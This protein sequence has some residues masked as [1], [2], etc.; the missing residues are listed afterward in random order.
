[1]PARAYDAKLATPVV[2]LGIRTIGQLLTEI[3][4]LPPTQ[5][6]SRQPMT[7]AARF[8]ASSSAIWRS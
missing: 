8:A 5:R 2:V 3:A 6:R 4:Y 1:M 7:L